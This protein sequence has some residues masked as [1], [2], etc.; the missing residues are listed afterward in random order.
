LRG[1]A[2]LYFQDESNVSLTAFLGKT[3]APCGKTPKA[4]VTGTRGCV[5]AISA[6]S[7]QGLLV[8]R[9][10]DKR[11]ASNEVIEFFSQMLQHHCRRHFVV[12]M[13]QATPHTSKMTREFI[14]SQKRLHVFYLP[15]YSP[16]WN[17]DEKVWKH[18]KT[19]ELKKHRNSNPIKQKQKMNDAF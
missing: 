6:I 14:E 5:S 1:R 8:F 7:G 16:D 19:Q 12:V 4:T 17:P 11:I 10:Y 9:L 2:I 3:W 18:L 13:D 15:P